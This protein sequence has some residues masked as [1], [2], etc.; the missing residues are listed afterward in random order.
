[1]G[2]L[3]GFRL[4]TLRVLPLSR[5][6]LL[7]LGSFLPGLLALL[8]R[9][10]QVLDLLAGHVFELLAIDSL[11]DVFEFLSRTIQ[12]LLRQLLLFVLQVFG[13]FLEQLGEFFKSGTAILGGLL[14][15]LLHFFGSFRLIKTQFLGKLAQFVLSE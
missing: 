13:S 9:I 5:S 4:L 12:R 15:A 14:Q 10:L 11:L 2:R 7:A 3:S 1:I 6:L 8:Q